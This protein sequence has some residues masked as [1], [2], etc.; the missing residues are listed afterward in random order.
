[1]PLLKE[2][3]TEVRRRRREMGLSQEALARL[4]GLS[5]ATVVNLEN[6]SLENLASTRIEALANAL[7]LAV[8]LVAPAS[9]Q[10]NAAVDAAARVASVPYR[11]KLPP[12]VLRDALLN[13]NVPPGY[14]PQMRTLL[15]EAP[16]GTLAAVVEEL[17]LRH[18]TAKADTW[19]R[20]RAL[21]GVLKCDRP[22]WNP[23]ST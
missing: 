13:G 15:Q 9:G 23:K 3:G 22:L 12:D 19:A 21:A 1:M 10:N 5:R 4:S 8:G 6:G 11:K 2:L 16:V 14:I 20:M 18:G 17:E 7:G